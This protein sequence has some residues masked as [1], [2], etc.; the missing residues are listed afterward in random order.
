VVFGKYTTNA[1]EGIINP[2][3]KGI[4]ASVAGGVGSIIAGGELENVA[5]KAVYG[6]LFNYL[7][8]LNSPINPLS[9]NVIPLAD[10]KIAANIDSFFDDVRAQG[11]DLK[12]ND[13]FRTNGLQ[14]KYTGNSYGGVGYNSSLHEAGFAFNVNWNNLSQSERTIVLDIATQHHIQWGG[15]FSPY[16]PVH[17]YV[18]SQG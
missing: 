9:R 11:I 7:E 14:T 4:A 2:M 16:D 8:H 6:Y 17:F 12:L 13:A 10:D 15:S 3:A 18:K 5:V 1:M